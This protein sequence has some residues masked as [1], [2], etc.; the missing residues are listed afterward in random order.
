VIVSS[1]INAELMVKKLKDQRAYLFRV[2]SSLSN[3]RQIKESIEIHGIPT[4]MF[5]DI[6]NSDVP[7]N[8]SKN[9]KIVLGFSKLCLFKDLYF[10]AQKL[11]V[12]GLA[13]VCPLHGP[14]R[15]VTIGLPE[16]VYFNKAADPISV[17]SFL[18]LDQHL[19]TKDV[20]ESFFSN[21]YDDMLDPELEHLQ[22]L[23][24]DLLYNESQLRV[25]M[26]QSNK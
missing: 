9:P 21:H 10:L 6:K 12:F 11:K 5:G 15:R 16:N 23:E 7:V 8:Y 17:D 13:E 25:M 3:S 14:L 26:D 19:Q 20:I 1:G 4:C 22:S 24:F 18:Q 2:D